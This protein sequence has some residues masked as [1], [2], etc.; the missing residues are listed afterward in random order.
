VN[1]ATPLV[2]W[3]G[4]VEQVNPLP[5]VAARLTEVDESPI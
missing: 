2:N 5:E 3:V 4:V 1:V